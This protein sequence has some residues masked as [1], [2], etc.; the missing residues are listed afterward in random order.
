MSSSTR[1]SSR[2]FA[3]RAPRAGVVLDEDHESSRSLEAR[4][5]SWRRL[6][7]QLVRLFT[8]SMNYRG[9]ETVADALDGDLRGILNSTGLVGTLSDLRLGELV[10]PEPIG[11]VIRSATRR[12][13]EASN[14]M[15]TALL[16]QRMYVTDPMT[17]EELGQQ[18]DVTRERI[19]QVQQR[20]VNNLEES[21][22]DLMSEVVELWGP[23]IPAVTTADELAGMVRG[24]L[25]SPAEE[26]AADDLAARCL[27]D[28]LGL[29]SVDRLQLS[30]EAARSFEHLQSRAHELAD[31]VGLLPEENLKED[32]VALAASGYWNELLEAAGV[33]RVGESLGLRQT[34]KAQV[35]AALLEIGRPATKEE[36]AELCGLDVKR[37]GSQLSVIEDVARSDK[38]RWGLVDWI[39]DVYEGIP[40]E[41]I[42]RIEEDGGVT[43]IE[44]VLEELPRLFD[45]SENSV[46][47]YLATPQFT[48]RD[49]HVSVADPST[50]NYRDLDDVIDGR[51]DA[52]EPYWTFT[53]EDRYLRGYSILGVPPEVARALGC[54]P[55]EAVRVELKHPKGCEPL[56]V[57]WRLSAT[58]GGAS[59]GY[60]ADP[61][62]AL[63]A[64]V[65]TVVRLEL[66]S[67]GRAS[68]A[69]HQDAPEVGVA[70]ADDLLQR[71]KKRRRAI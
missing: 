35:K 36:I 42:Q 58:T 23:S 9:A 32:F 1:R 52:G 13:I 24:F 22:G 48:V 18:F 11:D 21:L 71:I 25:G 8:A 43:S 55:N 70:G 15:E 56:S 30:A 65:G 27:I 67:D 10:D 34:A 54:G 7:E 57:I 14:P 4:R 62:K 68:V 28:R 19:R 59:V 41:I 40:A 45:V 69:L 31:G 66:Q 50:L 20:A 61:L 2:A 29:S 33:H 38:H 60:L 37:L 3:N 39:D 51:N 44:R 53:V 26:D 12:L 5:E 16:A 46:R 6:E 49:G 17:L 63:D 47:T 64:R